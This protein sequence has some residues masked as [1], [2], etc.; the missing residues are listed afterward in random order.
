[1]PYLL[2]VSGNRRRRV[3]D[4]LKK[5]GIRYTAGPIDGYLIAYDLPQ[6]TLETLPPGVEVLAPISEE[7]IETMSRMSIAPI[8]GIEIKDMVRVISGKFSGFH[9]IVTQV[10]DKEVSIGI[11]IFGKVVPVIVGRE[12]VEKETAPDWV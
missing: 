9:G 12:D 1:M 11:N 5:Q 7:E 4:I 6:R 8:K 3:A 2:T 10:N